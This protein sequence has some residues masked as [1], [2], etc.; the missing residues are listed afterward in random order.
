MDVLRNINYLNVDYRAARRPFV[1]FQ[2]QH[3]GGIS[4]SSTNF[5]RMPDRLQAAGKARAWLSDGN[6][7]DA[8]CLRVNPANP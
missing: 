3:A 8:L 1:V 2:Q 5:P 7:S 6:E 4:K